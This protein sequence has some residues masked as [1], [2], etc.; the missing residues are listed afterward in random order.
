M[1]IP[2]SVLLEGCLAPL[3][4]FV[5]PGIGLPPAPLQAH[6]HPSTPLR[7]GKAPSAPWPPAPLLRSLGSVSLSSL[8]SLCSTS[9]APSGRKAP[10]REDSG[11][12]IPVAPGQHRHTAPLRYARGGTAPTPPPGH[13]LHFIPGLAFRLRARG[14]PALEVI[15][16]SVFP[17]LV[18]W[19]STMPGQR[20]LVPN[21]I[22]RRMVVVSGIHNYYSPQYLSA[23]GP[24]ANRSYVHPGTAR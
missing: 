1:V 8:R 9:L 16:C 7:E 6:S 21:P 17:K 4:H 5:L 23:F 10:R 14:Y 13:A 11:C 2:V 22:L 19:L 24:T 20:W 15:I 18:W 3:L 12:C